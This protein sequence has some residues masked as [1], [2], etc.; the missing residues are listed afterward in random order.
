MTPRPSMPA[1]SPVRSVSAIVL[2][3]ARTDVHYQMTCDCLRS[4]R[5]H[6]GADWHVVVVEQSPRD[7]YGDDRCQIV[8][9]DEPFHYNRFLRLGWDAAE[10]HGDAVAIL[11]NDLIFQPGFWP[12]L[13]EALARFDS[14][15]PWCPGYHDAWMAP[16]H[17]LYRL[18]YRPSY[19][20]TGW[21]LVFRCDVEE[22]IGFDA[23]FP[24]DFPAWFQDNW[25]AY[26]LQRHGLT[27]ALVSASRVAHRFGGSR[28]LVPPTREAE[29]SY[30]AQAAFDRKV[31]EVE[32]KRT[33]VD[34][35]R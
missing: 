6:G 35:R 12:P 23:L 21:A 9:V 7:R 28:D 8:V 2:S 15:S 20:L 19:E 24:D 27:H 5:A 14:V 31:A 4:L 1:R 34:R 3:N 33:D 13:A 11:N 29:W 18:G 25:Y 30:V 17:D 16:P 22:R 10:T 32:R 26:Q